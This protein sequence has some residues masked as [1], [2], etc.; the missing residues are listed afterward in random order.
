MPSI[1]INGQ[2]HEFEPG[3]TILQVALRQRGS[4][5]RTTAITRVCR[6]PPA[7]GSAWPRSGPRI[8]R[9][10]GKLEAMAEARARPASTP[11]G[12]EHGRSTPTAPR[13]SR[14]RRPVMESAADQP[15]RSTARCAIRRGSASLQDYSYQY[16]RGAGVDSARNRRSSSPRRSI[17]PSTCCS[18]QRPLHHVHALRAVHARGD[19]HGRA[20]GRGPR[21]ATGADRRLPRDGPRQR[22]RRVT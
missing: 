6:S 18:I 4:R 8:P 21:F 12:D 1:T 16:G 17:G 5:S 2:A 3:E 15:S 9:N 13:R 19:R 20:D 10:E 22:T 14:T 11:A 7:A